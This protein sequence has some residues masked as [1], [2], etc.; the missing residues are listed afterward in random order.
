MSRA[1]VLGDKDEAKHGVRGGE[2]G[3]RTAVQLVAGVGRH[4]GDDE[5]LHQCQHSLHAVVRIEARR[6]DGIAG[7]RPPDQREQRPKAHDA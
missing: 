3:G 1:E 4:G 5:H 7:P 2:P 6:E